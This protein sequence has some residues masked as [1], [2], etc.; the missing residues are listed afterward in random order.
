M[1]G[2]G[3]T[4]LQRVLTTLRHK[5]PDRVGVS[6]SEDLCQVKAAARGRLTLV[7]NLN[8]VEMRR[9]TPEKAEEIVKDAISKA[10]R[11]GGFILSDNHGEIPWQ[12]PESVLEAQSNAIHK[13]GRYPLDWINE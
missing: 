1:N 11:G 6:F 2:A 3:F 5:E 4:S 9:W 12:V 7:G 8:G 10:A 13:W